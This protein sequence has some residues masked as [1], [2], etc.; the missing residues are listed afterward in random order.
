MTSIS[1]ASANTY[2]SPLQR[3]QDEL[4]S[5]VT[6]GAIG[7]SDQGALSSALS[8]ID[9]SLQGSRAADQTSGTKPSPGDLKSKINDLINS[10]VSSGK[11]TSD[12][13][14]ELQGIF[15]AAFANGPD[16]GGAGGTGGPQAAGGVHHGHHGH[17]E[18]HGDPTPADALSSTDG[19]NSSSSTSSTSDIL[20]QFLQ[21]LQDSLSASSSTTYSAKGGSDTSNGN[22]ASFSALLINYQA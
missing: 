22:S 19:T 18:G 15:K 8:D 2:Q 14:T 11:L 5:E 12:Q 3:L 6:S 21:S 16:A 1:A 20:Q 4:Q 9:S 10:E 13:A 17:H 7:A